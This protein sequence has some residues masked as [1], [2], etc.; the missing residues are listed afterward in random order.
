MMIDGKELLTGSYN[1]SINAEHS[2]FENVMIFRG[3]AYAGLVAAYIANF[4]SVWRTGEGTLLEDLRES[5]ANDDE[6]PIVFPSMALSPSHKTC[7]R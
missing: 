6:F 1:L 4:E 2:T 3:P 5:I 7:E